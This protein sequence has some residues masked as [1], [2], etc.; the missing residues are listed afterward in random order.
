M[1]LSAAANLFCGATTVPLV[2]KVWYYAAAC[3]HIKSSPCIWIWSPC[4]SQRLGRGKSVWMHLCWKICKWDLSENFFYCMKTWL[5]HLPLLCGWN[6]SCC[7]FLTTIVGNE[8]AM[9]WYVLPTLCCWCSP[10]C[11]SIDRLI[12]L[13]VCHCQKACSKEEQV[14]LMNQERNLEYRNVE[15]DC[16]VFVCR[17]WFASVFWEQ[18]NQSVKTVPSS[19]NASSSSGHGCCTGSV[20]LDSW[21]HSW[22]SV[23]IRARD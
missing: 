13:F 15:D 1:C 5:L 23:V 12:H 14:S 6:L 20:I 4:K 11:C 22:K 7:S 17:E 2:Q 10:C 8:S 21:F 18:T 19:S 3:M 9:S 16:S